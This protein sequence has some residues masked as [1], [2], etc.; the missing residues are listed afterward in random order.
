MI[1][2]TAYAK[3]NLTLSV[4]ERRPDG[5]HD[6]DSVMHSIS[7]HDT[8]T[9]KKADTVSLSILKGS[10]PAG[11][12]NLM[13]KAAEHFL[14]ARHIIGGVS[15]T[16]AKEIPSEAGMGGGS[17][18]AAAVLRGLSALYETGD[19]PETL[20]ALGAALG[21]DI[22]FC[23][24]AGVARCE[25]IGEKLTPLPSWPGLPLLIV[26]PQV[27]VSTAKAY[28]AIDA[29]GSRPENTTALCVKALETRDKNLLL[30]SLSNDF[31]SALFP[32]H[33]ILCETACALRAL[34]RPVLM[35]GSG[36]AFFL[37]L[38]NKKEGDALR[39]TL[40]RDHPLWF[41]ETAETVAP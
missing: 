9:L 1:Q 17:S 7:L 41:V 37:L 34:S 25:G 6:I 4:G 24:L 14:A 13:V 18:D 38:E 20:T 10:A 16:L 30:S 28:A 35:T 29:R 22:P 15:M 8:I 27:S 31:E 21:A 33:P 5:Y 40:K 12:D 19:T 2:E 3:I 39:E 26:R 36:S 32:T 23:V 11:R